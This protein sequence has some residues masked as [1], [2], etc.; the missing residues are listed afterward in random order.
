MAKDVVLRFVSDTRG[1]KKGFAEASKG[2]QETETLFARVSGSLGGIS[3]EALGAA[4]G[5]TAVSAGVIKFAQTAI[6]ELSNQQK[7]QA[8]TAAAIKSTGGAAGVTAGQ[9][10]TMADR[11][12]RMSGIDDEVVQSGE[13]L[14]LTFTNIKNGVGAG[15]DVFDQATKAALDMSVALGEDMASS[16]MRVGKALNDPIAGVTALRRV[17]VQL[18]DQ[19][20]QT[21]KGF[22]AT[23]NTMA[24]Q[25]VILQ[26]LNKEF[27]GSAEAFGN[28]LP[29]ALGKART[30]FDNWAG[31][32]AE[33]ALPAVEGFVGAVGD[34]VDK[35]GPSFTGALKGMGDVVLS[36][37]KFLIDH[38]GYVIAV[39]A[40][41][42]GTLIPALLETAAAFVAA[43]WAKLASGID[44]VITSVQV[45]ALE[46]GTLRL[47]LVSTGVGALVVL[48]GGL[49]SSLMDT[50]EAAKQAGD[51][52]EKSF[53]LTTFSGQVSAYN[54]EVQRAT[55]SADQFKAAYGNPFKRVLTGLWEAL[56]FTTDKMKELGDTNHDAAK[57]AEEHRQAI[58]RSRKTVTAIAGEYGLSTGEVERLAKAH[59]VDLSGAVEDTEQKLRDAI[60]TTA[61]AA[62]GWAFYGGTIEDVAKLQEKLKG[63]FEDAADP[64]NVFKDSLKEAQQVLDDTAKSDDKAMDKRH[65]AEKKALED[66]K[67]TGTASK[68]V[69]D[70]KMKELEERQQAEKDAADAT[71]KG[72]HKAALSMEQYRKKVEENTKLVRKWMTNIVTVGARAEQAIPGSGAVVMDQLRQLGPEQAGLIEEIAKSPDKSFKQF[73]QTMGDAGKTATDLLTDNL[74]K[75]PDQLT[76]VANTSGQ[77]FANTLLQQVM[78][79]LLPLSAIVTEAATDAVDAAITAGRQKLQGKNE[80][81]EAGRAGYATPP[82]SSLASVGPGGLY[83]GPYIPPGFSPFARHAEG[84]VAQVA[85]AGSWRLWAEPE[86]GGEAYIPLAS[87]KRARST[88][89]LAQVAAHFGH[90]LIPMAQGGMWV[91]PAGRSSDSGLVGAIGQLEQRLARNGGNQFVF[92]EKIDPLHA[93]AKIAWKL[94]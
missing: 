20:E 40:V 90:G 74:L 18:N 69:H 5:F 50:G 72:N 8:Q 82:S 76:T 29:G 73:V 6:T 64:V 3:T 47:A 16:A 24:A 86:T 48:L 7:A 83:L 89:L 4:A 61:E 54:A 33:N 94:R 78:Q 26:E 60:G 11:L 19:Q 44:L 66:E 31:S 46:M 81:R 87:S 49:L 80:E 43:N 21:I 68:A 30:A 58:E 34:V 32:V 9:I 17:G 12:S 51:A 88:A 91:M 56:P 52:L 23:G 36:V 25:R 10:G 79:G 55:Q 59:S 37:G 71:A 14:L 63:A 22:M 62:R 1:L 2:A 39:A 28:T 92:H 77:E 85:P 42:I 53:D 41:Y 67:I 45:L 13:N 70:R 93:A 35:V 65:K 27:G 75:L 15:N 84:H 57:R 38:K